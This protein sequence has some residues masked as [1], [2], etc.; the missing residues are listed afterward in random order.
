MQ[1]NQALIATLQEAIDNIA[2]GQARR[3]PRL[4]FGIP[5]IDER[6]RGGLSFGATHE[7][8]GGG[9]DAIDGAASSLF[10]AGI[11]ARTSGPIFWS[12]V[13]DDLFPPG[14]SQVGLDL[15]R[16]T[17]IG[18]RDDA[19]VLN[20]A[21][22]IIRQGGVAACVA[23]TVRLPMVASRRLQ[24][25]AEKTG[26]MGLIVRRWRRQSEATDYGMPTASVT[27]WR[28]SVCPSERLPAAG[29]GRRRWLLELMR[30]R[31]G[32]CFEIEVG[33]CDERGQMDVVR[34]NDEQ[35]RIAQ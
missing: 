21:E 20:S 7:I 30:A 14:L 4:P 22:E 24:L 1:S 9:A 12:F 25:A 5:E 2:G 13:R 33:G 3:R 23:E 32:D 26:T 16:V 28:I 8:A 19:E 35:H 11:A 27:R 15:E 18:C 29:V 17:F 6:L 10:A 34:D 31:A